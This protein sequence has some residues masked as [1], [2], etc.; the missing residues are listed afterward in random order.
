MLF[1]LERFLERRTDNKEREL[2]CTEH[3]STMGNIASVITFRE[4]GTLSGPRALLNIIDKN[5]LYGCTE[6]KC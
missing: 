6:K 4:S 3:Q 5:L 1:K 2:N